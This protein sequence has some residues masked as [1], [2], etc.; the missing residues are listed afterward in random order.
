MLH[1][2]LLPEGIWGGANGM[3]RCCIFSV[4]TSQPTSS[5]PT[6][7]PR[8]AASVQLGV[9]PKGCKDCKLRKVKCDEA[10]P[11]CSRCKT[12]GRDC[13]YFNT[14]KAGQVRTPGSTLSV[15]TPEPARRIPSEPSLPTPTQTFPAE[16]TNTWDGPYN[17]SLLHFELQDHYREHLL[18]LVDSASPYFSRLLAR[19]FKDALHTPYLMDELLAYAAAHKSTLQGEHCGLYRTESTKLQ[20]RALSAFR[21]EQ[22]MGVAKPLATFVFSALLGQHVLFDAFSETTDFPTVLDRFA[23]CVGIHH[24]IRTIAGQH[25]DKISE[26]LRSDR[27]YTTTEDITATGTDCDDLLDNLKQSE[28]NQ[29]TLKVYQQTIRILQY[30]LDSVQAD[31]GRR[32]MAVQEWTIRISREY[33]VLLQQRRPEAIVI[34]AY[35]AV[36]LHYAKDYWAIGG[37]GKFLIGS[38]SSHLGHY[39][40]DWL[41]WPNQVVNET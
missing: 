17:Y 20:T 29:D 33:I 22:A 16:Y 19:V 37:S 21:H 11:S 10:R 2:C 41:I 15:P 40:A 7:G 38:I 25:W 13:S 34:L 4:L 6:P 8:G 35:Y 31:Y 3:S 9:V 5:H 27:S 23:Q 36:L 18:G 32:I 24:G 39:W 14:P 1:K 28:L 30:L 26:H 12:N